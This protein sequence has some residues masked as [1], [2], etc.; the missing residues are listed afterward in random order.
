[1]FCPYSTAISPDDAC[2][3]LDIFY[4]ELQLLVSKDHLK[5][6]ATVEIW[7]GFEIF[8]PN[9]LDLIEAKIHIL[10]SKSNLSDVEKD[11]ACDELLDTFYFWLEQEGVD[12][13]VVAP[14]P[15]AEQESDGLDKTMIRLQETLSRI[16]DELVYFWTCLEQDVASRIDERKS[17][18]VFLQPYRITCNYSSSG[19]GPHSLT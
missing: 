2:R 9:S 17:E 19:E 16:F 7:A 11:T 3:I 14:N 18:D 15:Y 6:N 5:R 1:M 10:L 4:D 13:D 12:D 8:M